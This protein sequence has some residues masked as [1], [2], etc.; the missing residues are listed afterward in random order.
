MKV[1][2][3]LEEAKNQLAEMMENLKVKGHEGEEED[4]NAPLTAS[5]MSAFREV[6]A[7]SKPNTENDHLEIN[8][9]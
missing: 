3:H 9:E 4:V 7:L 5:L 8:D 1:L 2:Q 6:L